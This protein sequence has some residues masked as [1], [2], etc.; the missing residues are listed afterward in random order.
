V[1]HISIATPQGLDNVFFSFLDTLATAND[2]KCCDGPAVIGRE[3]RIEDYVRNH[4][5]QHR[6]EL[7][8]G[9]RYPPTHATP[10]VKLFDSTIVLADLDGISCQLLEIQKNHHGID[11]ASAYQF[12]R[13]AIEDY[14]AVLVEPEDAKYK[15]RFMMIPARALRLD[16]VQAFQRI[17]TF[18]SELGVPIHNS[19]ATTFSSS[20]TNLIDNVSKV[21]NSLI[22]DVL[23]IMTANTSCEN[24]LK[25]INKLSQLID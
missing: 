25:V 1:N 12:L 24:K 2:I 4:Q 20:A 11:L 18:Y 13:Q 19:V 8:I 22:D 17:E 14:L 10:L 16:A 3:L 7:L 5:L 9:Y 21:S 6:H 15:P 23:N